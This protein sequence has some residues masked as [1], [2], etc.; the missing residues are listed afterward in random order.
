M[1][2]TVSPLA[3]GT[4][5]PTLLMGEQAFCQTQKKAERCLL[6]LL[7]LFNASSRS[8]LATQLLETETTALSGVESTTKQILVGV[9]PAMDTLTRLTSQG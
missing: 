9:L 8:L 1:L 2:I 7:N 3:K 6:C 5:S 4:G